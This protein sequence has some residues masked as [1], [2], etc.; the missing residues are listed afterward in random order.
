MTDAQPI[1]TPDPSRQPGFFETTNAAHQAASAFSKR[2][3]RP[4]KAVVRYAPP[5]HHITGDY[6]LKEHPTNNI[7][8]NDNRWRWRIDY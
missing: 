7:L 8:C 4:H 5:G 2:R 6:Y 3:N 1:H